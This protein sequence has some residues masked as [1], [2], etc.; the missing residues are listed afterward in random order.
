MQIKTVVFDAYGTLFDVDAAARAAAAH[1]PLLAGCWPHL[2]ADW[3]RKHLE[4]SWLHSLMGLYRPFD[5]L[6]TEALDWAMAAH[7]LQDIALRQRLLDLFQTLPAY[8]EAP[9]LLTHLAQA[10]IRR[11]ILTNANPAMITRAMA[12]AGL[13]GRFDAVL[14]ADAVGIYKPAPQVY[15]LVLEHFAVA[16][17]EVLFVS[18]NG[19]DIAGAGAF[20]FRTV[21]VNRSGLP[22][23]HL[24]HRPTHILPDLAT[25]GDLLP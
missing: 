3:R 15:D 17:A 4:Y 23:D 18:S 12:S 14:S 10:Q 7:G 20:G 16:P 11:A 9:S 5:M 24:P 22:V 1:H 19:W 13:T 2:S 25:L 6:A 8:P 21:W